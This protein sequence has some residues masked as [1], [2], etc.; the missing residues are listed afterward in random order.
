MSDSVLSQD[1]VDCLLNGGGENKD[2]S[3]TLSR[4]ADDAIKPYDP[5][6]QRRV[7][8][9]RLCTLEFINER[10]AR[11]FRV[12]T[13]NVLHRSLDVTVGNIKVQP[14]HE[15]ARN[16]PVM[17]NLNLVHMNPLRGTGLFVFSPHLVFMLVDKLFGGDGRFKTKADGREF[18]PTEQ[19]IIQR[20]L[21]IALEAYDAAWD[22]IFSLK[23]EYIRSELQVKFTNITASPNDIVITT[24]FYIELGA[25]SAQLDVCIPFSTIEPLRELLTNPP[26]ENGLAQDG[27]WRSIL[28]SQVRDT[29]VELVVNL[30]ETSAR[31]STVMNLQPDDILPLE[32]PQQANGFVDGVQVFSGRFGHADRRYA[33][34]VEKLS[35]REWL[36]VNNKE[37]SH[38]Q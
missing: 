38:E 10:F 33:L 37:C 20:L 6:R 27:R 36:S 16:L 18:T 22:P 23:T 17:T 26:Q 32:K 34:Q 35:G 12:G 29:E 4:H 13:F 21:S 24:P 9:E 25:E 3:S 15:F 8:H 19:R 2:T 1:E 7:I 11:Q 31:L 30:F 28:A 5:H 14:Y